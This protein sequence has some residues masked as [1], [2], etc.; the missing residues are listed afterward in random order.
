MHVSSLHKDCHDSLTCTLTLL[1]MHLQLI[2]PGGPDGVTVQPV[3]LDDDWDLLPKEVEH[4]TRQVGGC[5]WV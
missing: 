1:R 5:L 3:S 2:V 4:I